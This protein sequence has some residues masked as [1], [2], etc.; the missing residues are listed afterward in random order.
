MMLRTR[1]WSWYSHVLPLHIT[2]V[3]S[4]FYA[5]NVELGACAMMSEQQ[6]KRKINLT[7]SGN[8][9]VCKVSKSQLLQGHLL[10]GGV[11][12]CVCVCVRGCFRGQGVCSAPAVWS[13]LS[14]IDDLHSPRVDQVTTSHY[15]PPPSE[16]VHSA[17]THTYTLFTPFCCLS[18]FPF[19][20][21]LWIYIYT[22]QYTVHDHLS[23][24]VTVGSCCHMLR[25]I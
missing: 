13:C 6:Q 14:L 18:P 11:C 25:V 19:Q 24:H 16:R 1:K 2:G 23:C 8:V 21:D 12:V 3:I 9:C 17:H 22:C 4:H 20:T 15:W 7:Q 5:N 10:G